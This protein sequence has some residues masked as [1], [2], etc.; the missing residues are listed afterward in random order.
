MYIALRITGSLLLC[1]LVAAYMSGGMAYAQDPA[2]LLNIVIVEGDGAINN[3]KQRT[4]REPIVEVQD[5]NHKPVAGATVLFA[6]PGNGPSA[7]FAQAGRTATF[8]TDQNGRV[9]ARGLQTNHVTGKF[10]MRVTASSQGRTATTV[11]T[12]TNVASAVAG[13]AVATGLSL[14]LILAIVAV[15]AAGAAG[16]AYAATHTG[17]TTKPGT[18]ITLGS[19]TV[20]PP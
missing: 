1:P 20:G 17:T 10:Q 8:I 5:E 14:K 16:G 2:P 15:A 7:A 3:I 4:V 18:T 13:T 9:V 19:P 6:L 12:Q 11:I